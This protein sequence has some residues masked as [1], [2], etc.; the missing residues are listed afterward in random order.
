M[1][2]IYV[3]ELG[4]NYKG[5][6]IYE[7]IFSNTEKEVWG[8]EWDS[9]PANGNPSPPHMEFI[10]KVATL[11]NSEIEFNLI[12]KSDFFGMYDSIDGIIALAWESENSNSLTDGVK[13]LVFQ[14]GENI[15]SVEDKFYERDIVLTYEKNLI[16]K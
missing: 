5:D 6:N 7:F 8:E 1:K 14:Y 3:N 12:Q 16:E 10:E 2:L 4:P 9:Q 15:K 11:K 13:R